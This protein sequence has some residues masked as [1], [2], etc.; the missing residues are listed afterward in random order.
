MD[1]QLQLGYKLI[2]IFIQPIDRS[3][4]YNAAFV[5][6]TIKDQFEKCIDYFDLVLTFKNFCAIIYTV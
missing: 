2:L 1:L 3:D 5:Y 6:R 4:S